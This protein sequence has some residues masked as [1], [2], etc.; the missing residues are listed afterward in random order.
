ML[1]HQLFSCYYMISFIDLHIF[2]LYFM[3][4]AAFSYDKRHINN[5]V[6]KSVKHK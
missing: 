4:F 3:S 1:I 2:S 6:M 5:N